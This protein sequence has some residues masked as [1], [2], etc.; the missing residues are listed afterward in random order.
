VEMDDACGMGDSEIK[1][2]IFAEDMAEHR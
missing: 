1:P 2:S